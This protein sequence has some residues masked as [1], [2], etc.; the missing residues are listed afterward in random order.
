M[1]APLV[2]D[3]EAKN[4]DGPLTAAEFSMRRVPTSSLF[5]VSAVLPSTDGMPDAEPPV[6][7]AAPASELPTLLPEEP[8]DQ[9][10]SPSSP[11]PSPDH[12]LSDLPPPAN[13]NLL[14]PLAE[15]QWLFSPAAA[16]DDVSVGGHFAGMFA[17]PHPRPP[18]PSPFFRTTTSND[19]DPS[20]WN[21]DDGNCSVP[22]KVVSKNYFSPG[23]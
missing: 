4:P 19:L 13:T 22:S 23:T 2:A 20:R 15:I 18:S 8:Y 14:D 17:H 5:P 10:L 11:H 21:D 9:E 12:D 6:S 3:A 7:A 1:E 16:G